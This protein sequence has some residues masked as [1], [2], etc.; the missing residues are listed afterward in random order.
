M[1]DNNDKEVDSIIN[2]KLYE[3]CKFLLS[4]SFFKEDQ[5]GSID[6]EIEKLR[7]DGKQEKLKR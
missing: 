7:K 5:I 6:K 1:I 3:G 2:Q 4:E